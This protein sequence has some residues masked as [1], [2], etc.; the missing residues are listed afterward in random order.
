MKK[1]LNVPVIGSVLRWIIALVKLPTRF[2]AL[3]FAI[4]Q[5]KNEFETLE[6]K[7]LEQEKRI[8]HLQMQNDH[9]GKLQQEL[10][11]WHEQLSEKHE[12]LSEKHEHLS[13]KHEQLSEKHEH[14]SEKYEQ[15]CEKH[16]QL[17]RNH[18]STNNEI[19]EKI[20]EPMRLMQRHGEIL[21]SHQATIVQCVKD[22]VDLREKSLYGIFENEEKLE[23]LNLE[24]SIHKTL[25][26]DSDR[27]HISPLAAVNSCFFNT[28]SGS[29]Y[30]D[31]YTFSGSGVS[32][33]TGSHDMY[34]S[35]YL[36]REYELKNQGDIKIGKGVWIASNVTILGPCTIGDNAVIA[37]GAVIKPGTMI[38]PNTVYAGVPAKEVKRIVC[39]SELESEAVKNIFVRE[40]GILFYSGW[41]ERQNYISDGE[42]FIG[43]RM[44]NKISYIYTTRKHISL[45]YQQETNETE[46][47]LI[48]V[49]MRHQVLDVAKKGIIELDMTEEV[50]EIRIEIKESSVDNVFFAIS[51]DKH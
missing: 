24:L 33:L 17:S 48:D 50:N 28:N 32:I 30:I 45:F 41:K 44:N 43:H 15:L 38:P 16:E 36:R 6:T 51:S 5:F 11:N 7:V 40:D 14:L 42:F 31:D 9:I 18:Q 3:F 37:A 4:D 34:L 25:W 26:G 47:I 19:V 29:I 49:N 13:E 20:N 27:L 10:M 1:I 22:I 35:G 12:H 23:K 2:D 8:E 21:Q 46:E 39:S